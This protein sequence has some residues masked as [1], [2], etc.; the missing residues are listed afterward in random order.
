[1]IAAKKEERSKLSP[2]LDFYWVTNDSGLAP[3]ISGG[4]LSLALCKSQ[5][6]KSASVG[7]MAIGLHNDKVSGS[8][9]LVYVA[10]WKEVISYDEYYR[11]CHDD[12]NQGGPLGFKIPLPGSTSYHH[13]VGI[14]VIVK[15]FG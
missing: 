5:I 7:D 11:K 2:K 12:A 13:Y 9:Y 3:N 8:K 10:C 4:R 15:A 14:V 6:R 1:M